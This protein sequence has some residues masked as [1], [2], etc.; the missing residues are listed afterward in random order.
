MSSCI[1]LASAIPNEAWIAPNAGSRLSIDS[2]ISPMVQLMM[3]TNSAK[4]GS[5]RRRAGRTLSTMACSR[6][7]RVIGGALLIA[8]TAGRGQS[9]RRVEGPAHERVPPFAWLPGSPSPLRGRAG[10]VCCCGLRLPSSDRRDVPRPETKRSAMNDKRSIGRSDGAGMHPDLNELPAWTD[11]YFL[12]SQATVQRV[13]DKRV[14]YAVFMRRPVVSAPRLCIEW[15]QQVAKARG[16]TFD[17]DLQYREGKW[18]G[19]G[20]PIMYISGSFVHLVDTE[21]IFLMK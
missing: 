7:G 1:S 12:R 8:R 5:R 17:I 16:T 21:T 4:D 11:H 20:E 13:G 6:L 14:T 15:M 10:G 2:D 9:A 3:P 19:A 18:V